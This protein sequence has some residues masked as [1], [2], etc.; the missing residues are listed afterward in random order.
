MIFTRES[1][2]GTFTLAQAHLDSPEAPD[3]V[4]SLRWRPE[5]STTG[6]P[7][8]VVSEGRGRKPGQGNH[9]G[10][11]R[12]DVHNTLVAAGPDFRAGIVDPLPTGNIDVAP[13]ILWL[14][15]VPSPRPMDGRVLSEAIVGDAPPVTHVDFRRLEA[16]HRS[17]DATWR[18]YLMTS[19]VNGV[20]YLDEGNGSL[21]PDK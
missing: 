13:T 14:F 7:G 6:A 17:P 5:A 9:A 4:V 10:L 3:V 2:E 20:L 16:E 15:G 18:Q 12:F 19:K 1:R 8:L 11:C 21:L